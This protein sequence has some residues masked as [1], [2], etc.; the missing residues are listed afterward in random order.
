MSKKSDAAAEAAAAAEEAEFIA[1]TEAD[2][3]DANRKEAYAARKAAIEAAK[4]A[5]DGYVEVGG[6]G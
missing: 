2:P 4:N 3:N 1:K 5:D 6:E